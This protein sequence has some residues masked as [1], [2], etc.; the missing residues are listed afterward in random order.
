MLEHL[1]PLI[2]TALWVG[3]TVWLVLRFA[4]PIE[5][6]ISALESRIETG[7]RIKAGPFE[8]GDLIPQN[9]EAQK[10]EV[11]AEISE[12]AAVTPSAV[13]EEGTV[14]DRYFQAEDLALRAIQDEYQSPLAR[15]VHLGSDL[16]VDGAFTLNGGLH[17][18]EVKYIPA[19]SPAVWAR[20]AL[21]RL[22]SYV[23]RYPWRRVSIILALVI[24]GSVTQGLSPSEKAELE[25]R[26]GVPT[27]ILVYDLVDLRRRFGA[28]NNGA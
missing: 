12:I 7:S 13:P 9:S 20:R 11:E 23:Q 21:D 25:Q 5:R 4:K 24:E 6:L 27:K 17:I 1:A 18:V 19:G 28:E 8:I 22:A 10:A 16:N 26:I 14:R 2:R 3:L 15:Q